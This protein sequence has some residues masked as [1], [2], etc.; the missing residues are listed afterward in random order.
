MFSVLIETHNHE[1]QLTRTLASLVSGAVEGLVR[2]VIVCDAGST[3]HTHIV[4]DHAGCRY[5]ASGGIVV[6]IRQAKAEWLIFMEPGARLCEGWMEAAAAHAGNS[7][8]AARFSRQRGG[9][10]PFL[11]RVFPA[12]RPLADGLLITKR[13]ADAIAQKS[14]DAVHLAR[15][16]SSRRIAARIVAA[17]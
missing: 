2:E 13:Q 9:A 8:G 1:A 16:V 10:T 5:I 17:P 3:D 12:R 6:G 4:A 15:G 11:A 7:N 14:A